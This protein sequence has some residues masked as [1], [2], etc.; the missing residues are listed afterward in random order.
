[1]TP[2]AGHLRAFTRRR[3]PLWFELA[4]VVWLCWVYD[5]VSNLAH[6]RLGAALAHARE[7]AHLER[8]VHLDPERALDH[9]L[10][11]HHALGWIVSTYYDNAHFVVTFGV[12]GWLWVR[13]PGH[14]R[15]LRSALALLNLAALGV[16]WL[17]PMAPPRMLPGYTDVVAATGAPGS[18]HSGALATHADEL[19]AMPSLHLAWAV[20][21]AWA[22][23]RVLR[24]RTRWAALAWLYPVSTAAAVLTT[25]NHF[26]A[27]VA[28]GVAL[29]GVVVP[30]ADRMSALHVR[31]LL[32]HHR[33]RHAHA[34]AD[35]P[36]LVEVP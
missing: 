21:S 32:H 3:S 17:W 1:M 27:D 34:G 20:W 28:A 19:A 18:W 9:W 22:L 5:A 13:H 33:R 12:L 8:V 2:A 23:W 26:V 15:P 4:V 25:G 6:L 35:A 11:A 14:Y 31:V 29:T 7:V 10:S 36:E 24:A 30:V 16:F